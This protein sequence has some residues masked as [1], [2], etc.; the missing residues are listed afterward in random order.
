MVLL[1]LYRNVHNNIRAWVIGHEQSYEYLYTGAPKGRGYYIDRDIEQYRSK[2][3]PIVLM[4]TL[5]TPTAPTDNLE[6]APPT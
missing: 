4:S 3:P 6:T 5:L 2:A 1:L